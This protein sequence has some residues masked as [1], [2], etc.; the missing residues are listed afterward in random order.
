VISVEPITEPITEVEAVIEQHVDG[1]LS[2]C[3]VE[4]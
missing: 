1:D 4:S 3:S 2:V